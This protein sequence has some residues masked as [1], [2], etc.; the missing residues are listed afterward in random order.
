[1][2]AAGSKAT[3]EEAKMLIPFTVTRKENPRQLWPWRRGQC[4]YY[5]YFTSLRYLPL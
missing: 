4:D 2:F 3:L 1:M 5:V